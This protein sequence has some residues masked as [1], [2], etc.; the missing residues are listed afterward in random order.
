M[1]QH[2]LTCSLSRAFS[3]SISLS[4]SLPLPPFLLLSLSL[5][6]S[7]SLPLSIPLPFPLPLHLPLAPSLPLRG[8][9]VSSHRVGDFNAHPIPAVDTR[10]PTPYNLHPSPCTLDPTTQTLHPTPFAL[11]PTPY[12]PHPTPYTMHPTLYTLHPTP[13]T[14]HS[15]S[16]TLPPTPYIQKMCCSLSEGCGESYESASHRVED[17]NARPTPAVRPPPTPSNRLF[18]F[19]DFDW[20]SPESGD[21]W[22]RSRRFRKTI[23]SPSEG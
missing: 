15:T 7:F 12:N 14:L 16:Y 19:P 11:Y 18:Q 10:H 2:S 20:S 1:P 5:S 22:Y 9:R 3:L 4:L 17:F 23:C 13:H 8:F 21:V 6:L